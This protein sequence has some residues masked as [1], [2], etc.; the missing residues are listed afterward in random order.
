M[1]TIN[2]QVTAL[3]VERFEVEE[4]DVDFDSSLDDI[5][6][7][8]LAQVE[9]GDV[10]GEIYHV[11]IADDEMTNLVTLRDIVAMLTHKGATVA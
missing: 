3:L 9:F 1:D 4:E 5:G 2:G 8:S 11:D 7:D 6:L 10:L